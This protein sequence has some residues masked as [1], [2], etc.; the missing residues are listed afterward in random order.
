MGSAEKKKAIVAVCLVVVM[1]FMWLRVITKKSGSV[2]SVQA[3]GLGRGSEKDVGGIRLSYVKLPE[4]EGRTD[5]LSRDFF[6]VND[7]SSFD[8]F[9]G[10]K[11]R[12]AQM[13][14]GAETEQTEKIKNAAKELSVGVIVLGQRPHVYIEGELLSAGQ[15]L[16]FKHRNESY[17][18][19]VLKIFENKI[20]LQCDGIAVVKKL[21]QFS[22]EP[23]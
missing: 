4:I 19:K 17:E 9:G 18:F 16:S 21:I 23:D 5:V 1:G 20:E 7:W 14:G 12:S 8:G 22:I 2:Q 15:S 10:L 11:D 3:S 13:I 6:A